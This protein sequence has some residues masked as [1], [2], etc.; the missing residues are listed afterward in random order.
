MDEQRYLIWKFCSEQSEAWQ[1]TQQQIANEAN[2][3]RSKAAK[4][5]HAKSNPRAGEKSGSRTECPTTKQEPGKQAK[6]AAAKVNPGAV[7]RGDKLAKE[8][9]DLARKVMRGEMKPAEADRTG[10]PYLSGGIGQ[11][12]EFRT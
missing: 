5:Q 11:P 2:A 8:R 6:A 7:A 1:S 12:A 9:P 3:K 10:A 4:E